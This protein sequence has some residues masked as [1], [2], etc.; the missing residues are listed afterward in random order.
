[1]RLIRTITVLVLATLAG[2]FPSIAVS[3]T[4]GPC[5]ASITCRSGS[6]ITCNGQNVCSWQY[7]TKSTR[8]YVSCD[9]L[10]FSCPPATG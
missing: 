7:D 6:R 2:A 5:T 10:T 9:G 4:P 1:M 3:Q 8:G